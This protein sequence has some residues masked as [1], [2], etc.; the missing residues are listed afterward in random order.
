MVIHMKAILLSALL[1]LNA[2]ASNEA[3]SGQI[4]IA[5]NL[6]EMFKQIVAVGSDTDLRGNVQTGSIL[7]ERMSI[8]GE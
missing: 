7:I 3:L 8:A 5:S 1:L 2:C 6:K 4:T